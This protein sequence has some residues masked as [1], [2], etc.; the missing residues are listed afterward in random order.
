MDSTQFT[1]LI[2]VHFRDAIFRKGQVLTRAEMG[3]HCY[4]LRAYGLVAEIAYIS[5]AA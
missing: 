5:V 2:D 4:V 1:V 3:S